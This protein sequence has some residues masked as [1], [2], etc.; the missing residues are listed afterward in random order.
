MCI[1]T[2]D[3]EFTI[4]SKI[5]LRFPAQ[6][7]KNWSPIGDRIPIRNTFDGPA[8]LF[9]FSFFCLKYPLNAT[10]F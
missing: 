1:W 10:H 7:C 9:L 8:T 5:V 2:F 4:E 6:W 3:L